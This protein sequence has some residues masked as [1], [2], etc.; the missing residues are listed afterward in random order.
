MAIS[1]TRSRLSIG[2]ASVTANRPLTVD[3]KVADHVACLFCRAVCS[4]LHAERSS[5]RRSAR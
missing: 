3:R 5:C 4:E 1:P 2:I